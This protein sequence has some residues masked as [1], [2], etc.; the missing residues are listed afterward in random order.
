M[1]MIWRCPDAERH[2]FLDGRRRDPAG[3]LHVVGEDAD[4]GNQILNGFRLQVFETIFW[5]QKWKKPLLLPP[6]SLM[7]TLTILSPMKLPQ[8]K[9]LQGLAVQDRDMTD[10]LDQS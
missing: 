1:V 9:I 6:Q 8:L 2:L 7:W 5:S 3:F 4:K 10:I